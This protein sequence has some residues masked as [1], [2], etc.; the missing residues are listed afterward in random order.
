MHAAEELAAT[1]V[2][3][4]GPNHVRP[5]VDGRY[6]LEEL[7]G[8]G[9]MGEVWRARDLAFD[10]PVAIKLARPFARE[11]ARLEA[12]T[13]TRVASPHVVRVK[14]AGVTV[15]DAPFLVMELL[16]G[17]TLAERLDRET[18]LAAEETVRLLRQA[19]GALDHAH[20]LGVVH[21]DVKPANL[22]VQRD[23]SVKLIDFG[24][25][26][27]EGMADEAMV[28]SPYYM[29]P[30][31]IDVPA[32]VGPS[33]DVWALGVVAYECLTGVVPFTGKT[34][35]TVL[36]RIRRGELDGSALAP[37]FEAWFRKACAVDP[38]ARFASASEA[39]EAL[40]AAVGGS[41][42]HDLD[43]PEVEQRVET[44][45]RLAAGQAGERSDGGRIGDAVDVPKD[46]RRRRIDVRRLTLELS[47]LQPQDARRTQRKAAAFEPVAASLGDELGE[48][49]VGPVLEDALGEREGRWKVAREIATVHLATG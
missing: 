4:R 30:E 25:A 27:V 31:Q 2:R 48:R 47:G 39:I 23:G 33:T 34:T 36:Y 24:V 3:E 13:T 32:L 42:V 17:E 44:I 35:A 29:A 11:R 37:S 9:T 1:H 49:V 45:E 40:A 7:L 21:R 41:A 28:G 18:C 19:A 16:S 15:D 5:R 46:E 20:A 22:F 38:E 10:L 14:D 12:Q 43:D 8:E 6:E 26:K